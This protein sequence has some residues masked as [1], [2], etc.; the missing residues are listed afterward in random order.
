MSIHDRVTLAA[1]TA[2]AYT[3]AGVFAGVV[4]GAFMVGGLS[5][6]AGA[7]RPQMRP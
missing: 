5:L 7:G 3:F 6:L 2:I 4:I 1:G